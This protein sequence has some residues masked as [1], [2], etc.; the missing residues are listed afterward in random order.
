MDQTLIDN[1][2]SSGANI[3]N[4]Y[5]NFKKDSPTRKT[6]DYF[7]KRLSTL[8]G[9]Y[10]KYNEC[11]AAIDN[12]DADFEIQFRITVLDEY[13]TY[14]QLLE[15]GIASQNIV[16]GNAATN[17][18]GFIA[19][20]SSNATARPDSQLKLA[21]QKIDELN[22]ENTSM[23]SEIE[24]LK[25]SMSTNN[26]NLR[27][28]DS[29]K[30]EKESLESQLSILRRNY[31]RVCYEKLQLQIASN[32]TSASHQYERGNPG[33][34]RPDDHSSLF[35]IK[36]IVKLIPK[37]S[38]NRSELR[39]YIN[40]CSELWSYA[41]TGADQAK[42]IT[43]LKTNLTGDAAMLLLDEDEIDDWDSIK[44][45]L[46]KNFNEDPNHS[47]NIALMQ[48]MKQNKDESV[49]AFCK[50]IKTI[51]TKLKSNI[52]DGATKQFWFDH[53]EKQA[54]Q[55]LEDGLADVKLQSRVVSSKHSTFNVASQ[56]AIETNNRLNSKS[57]EHNIQQPQQKN[58]LYCNYCK[59]N[60]H[61]I[62][63]CRL[64]K[65]NEEIKS[66]NSES[67]S[68]DWKC[69][70]C[71]RNTHSTDICYKNPKNAKKTAENNSNS[72]PINIMHT[73]N[74]TDNNPASLDVWS[75]SEN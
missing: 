72:A 34:S 51:L 2:K 22:A 64:R 10:A 12:H 60:T 50:R 69:T 14:L 70:I 35:S 18:M 68:D 49:D 17:I 75:D 30:Y 29:L 59:K 5:T 20:E 19:N 23:K 42:F 27:D 28:Y 7:Q 36:E 65:K 6:L 71:K 8:N 57:L 74:E 45:L 44:K 26:L 21:L 73:E 55:A 9:L 53:T 16:L 31:D 32:S 1:F 54:I 67:K 25:T 66:Q 13:Q 38:G 63:N 41:R 39:V 46:N 56:Y 3:L 24:S 48:R 61:S 4:A 62:E 33:S 52:P 43:V 40:K 11:V 58:A 37:F 47:N 15:Q